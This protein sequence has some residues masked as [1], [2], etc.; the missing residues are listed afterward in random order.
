MSLGTASPG[1]LLGDRLLHQLPLLGP[2]FRQLCPHTAPCCSS[3]QAKPT[4]CTPD[5]LKSL[6]PGH[7]GV[8]GSSRRDGAHLALT[9]GLVGPPLCQ[10]R[11][12]TPEW[13]EGPWRRGPQVG[14]PVGGAGGERPGAGRPRGQAARVVLHCVRGPVMGSQ[15]SL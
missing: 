8:G 10:A 15:M 11:P 5:G 7:M 14:T 2:R 12:E 6:L 4:P 9:K 1:L 3:A 13:E